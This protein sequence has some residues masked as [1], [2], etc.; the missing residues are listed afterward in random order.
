MMLTK[1]QQEFIR[2]FENIIEFDRLNED[3]TDKRNPFT[4]KKPKSRNIVCLDG[5][6]GTGKSFL[7]KYILDTYKDQLAFQVVTF[8]NKAANVLREKGLVASTIHKFL[9][10]LDDEEFDNKKGKS[11]LKF[12]VNLDAKFTNDN[13]KPRWI[14]V[15][16]AGMVNDI[17]K[18][19]IE[20]LGVSVLYVG[21][22]FQN[23]PVSDGDKSSASKIFSDKNATHFKMTE[24]QRYDGPIL[25][26]S[27]A[28]RNDEKIP[29]HS[30]STTARYKTIPNDNVLLAADIVIA[31]TNKTKT[32][33]NNK[34][35]FLK[36]NIPNVLHSPLP[37]ERIVINKNN[38]DLKLVNSDILTIT[39]NDY[40][41]PLNYFHE[42]EQPDY[43]LTD[44]DGKEYTAKLVF[45]DYLD[46]DQLFRFRQHVYQTYNKK[47]N[48]NSSDLDLDELL[49]INPFVECSFAYCLTCHKAQ[50]SEYD[51]V[52]VVD[53]SF[54]FKDFAKNWLYTAITRA[55]DKLIIV[56]K[57]Y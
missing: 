35:R 55:K 8:T 24:V 3:D 7:I 36:Y 17:I 49:K 39:T 41:A 34:I 2:L 56:D 6:A 14:I 44:D 40:K 50:G 16:E 26:M 38:A 12:K 29:Y 30:T 57:I 54:V 21:D 48:L 31:G 27:I 13:G 51:K 4:N 37:N 28:I 33:I 23:P 1:E 22:S 18:K 53:Q 19:D 47:F 43:I 5:Y 11:K 15:D 20:A 42:Q 46:S 9:Y 25:A 10:T 45:T 52:L 32:H